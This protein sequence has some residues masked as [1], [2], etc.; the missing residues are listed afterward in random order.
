MKPSPLSSRLKEL[1]KE[2]SHV[3]SNIR[4]LARGKSLPRAGAAP[5]G[6]RPLAPTEAPPPAVRRDP[7]P[8]RPRD[9]R[10]TDYLASSLEPTRPLLHERRLQRNKAIVALVLALLAL[11]W[12][13]HRFVG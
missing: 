5:A 6:T 9:E 1:E 4:T 10:F 2:L 3:D 11:F 7:V 8:R 12:V 13:L